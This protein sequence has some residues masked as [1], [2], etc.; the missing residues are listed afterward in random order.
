MDLERVIF[1]GQQ[2]ERPAIWRDYSRQNRQ[3]I[4]WSIRGG[5]PV[6]LFRGAFAQIIDLY[7][8]LCS[9]FLIQ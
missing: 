5:V 8:Y 1:V 9:L 3:D 2:E 7:M 6:N 4:G